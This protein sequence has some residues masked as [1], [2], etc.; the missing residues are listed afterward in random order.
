MK[1]PDIFSILKE[2][3]VFLEIQSNGSTI[4][5]IYNRDFTRKKN[6]RLNKQDTFTSG[7]WQKA[8]KRIVSNK[9]EELAKRFTEKYKLY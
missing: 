2:C 9:D 8:N 7:L 3:N 1:H 6:Y 5:T 4:P